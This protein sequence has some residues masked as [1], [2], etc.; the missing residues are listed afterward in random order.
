MS[1]ELN[2]SLLTLAI[3]ALALT[4]CGDKG[5]SEKDKSEETTTTAEETQV[6]QATTDSLPLVGGVDPN[7]QVVFE[8]VDG[9]AIV[10]GDIVLGEYDALLEAGQV[11]AFSYP[12]AHDAESELNLANDN[13]EEAAQKSA[14]GGHTKW[15]NGVVPFTIR[16][17]N[18]SSSDVEI[19]YQAM[20]DISAAANIKFVPAWQGS[21]HIEIY[22]G[23]GCSS[24]V[25]RNGGKQYLSLGYGCVSKGIVIHEFMHALGFFHEQSRA[26]RDDYVNIHWENIQGNMQYNFSKLGAVTTSFSQ[27]DYNSIMHYEWYAFSWNGKATISARQPGVSFGQRIGLSELDI[28]SLQ[29]AYGAPISEVPNEAPRVKLKY[30]AISMWNN[31]Q[32]YMPVELFDDNDSATDLEFSYMLDRGNVITPKS[33]QN[34]LVQDS[35]NKNLFYIP[36]ESLSPSHIGIGP[37]DPNKTTMSLTFKDSQGA[38]TTVDLP[39]YVYTYENYYP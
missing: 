12:E 11:K 30:N 37:L 17:G 36:L 27:Y 39:I 19:M 16:G 7:A 3:G 24:A 33:Y 34:M 13:N 4:G 5:S 22:R 10:E 1:F 21:D 25:G 35:Y 6:D 28:Y 38:E 2:K 32:Y 14:W 15:T 9:K 26:D 20:A 8:V 18:F 31:S 29:R 23:N